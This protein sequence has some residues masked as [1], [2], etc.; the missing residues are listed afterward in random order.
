[1]PLQGHGRGCHALLLRGREAC[2]TASMLRLGLAGVP[3]V[4]VATLDGLLDRT[5]C[6][7]LAPLKGELLCDPLIRLLSEE[8]ACSFPEL[9]RDGVEALREGKGL[10]CLPWREVA[11]LGARAGTDAMVCL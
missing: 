11:A 2:G 9:L 10:A 3:V 6:W 5:H 8:V 7:A 1:M 4:L